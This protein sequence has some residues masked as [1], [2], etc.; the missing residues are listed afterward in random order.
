M[1]NLISMTDF[2]LKESANEKR[3]SVDNQNVIFRYALFF[4]QPLELWMFVPCELV[5]NEF[6]NWQPMEMPRKYKDS[7]EYY[8]KYQQA[9]ERCLFDGFSDI[10]EL[11]QYSN[12]ISDGMQAVFYVSKNGSVYNK[13]SGMKTIEDLTNKTPIFLTKTALKQIGL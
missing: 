11:P 7:F 8:D 6:A 10:K 2:V 1:K 12:Y 13:I 4:K 3:K 5:G 9:K